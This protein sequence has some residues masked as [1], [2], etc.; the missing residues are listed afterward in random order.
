MKAFEG[1]ANCLPRQEGIGAKAI[2]DHIDRHDRDDHWHF[3][4]E[5]DCR[6][7]ATAGA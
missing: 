3:V 5:T 6:H 1:W 2:A 4:G 7:R